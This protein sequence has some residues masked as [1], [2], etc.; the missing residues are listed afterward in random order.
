MPPMP[1]TV[2]HS[3]DRMEPFPAEAVGRSL[4][5]RFCMSEGFR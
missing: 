5:E 4:G 1:E 2:A 3:M